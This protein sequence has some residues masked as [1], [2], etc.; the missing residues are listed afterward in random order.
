MFLIFTGLFVPFIFM[1]I[2]AVTNGM[3]HDISIY[4][5]SVFNGVSILGR[6]LPAPIADKYGRFNVVIVMSWLTSI[7]TLA[8]WI[9]ANSNTAR[10]LYSAFF[11]FSSGAIVSMGPAMVA[12]ISDVRQIGIRTGTMYM[13]V[14]IAVLVGNPI[15]ASLVTDHGTNYDRLKIFGG[16]LMCGGSL[17]L[18]AARWSLSD[19]KLMAKV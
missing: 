15:A 5:V 11:G 3:S 10:W 13:F 12:Q 14:A 2:E 17:V 6:T 7:F 16:C 4:L 18:M 19:G 1:S 9:P 8:I